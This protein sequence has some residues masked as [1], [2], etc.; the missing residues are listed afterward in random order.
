MIFRMTNSEGRTQITLTVKIDQQNPVIHQGK[1]MPKIQAGRGFSGSSFVINNGNYVGHSFIVSLNI[2][3]SII[4]AQ[5][6]FVKLKQ[7][8]YL[9]KPLYIYKYNFNQNIND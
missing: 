6:C 8:I 9:L 1:R 2:Q 5:I 7:G 4:Y 3:K